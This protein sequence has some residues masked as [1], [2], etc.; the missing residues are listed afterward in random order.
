MDIAGIDRLS[1]LIKKNYPS[2]ASQDGLIKAPFL[3]DLNKTRLNG[4]SFLEEY[5]YNK[6]LS[7][8]IPF[9]NQKMDYFISSEQDTINNSRD[10][11][12]KTFSRVFVGVH[13][14]GLLKEIESQ[15]DPN[16]FKEALLSSIQLYFDGLVEGRSELPNPEVWAEQL[17]TL[18]ALL[19][20]TGTTVSAFYRKNS[21]IPFDEVREVIM[22]YDSRLIKHGS[23]SE[24][25]ERH[26]AGKEQQVGNYAANIADV[27]ESE[28][29]DL[30]MP[31]ASGGFEP[32]LLT[33]DYLG[34]KHIFP[35][36]YS[37]VSRNDNGVLVPAQ[38]PR[39]YPQQ[40]IT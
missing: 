21:E 16:N 6:I 4:V 7:P 18:N 36:R 12:P 25:K 30:I 2:Y 14:S 39:D 23:K 13:L 3:D 38:A 31:V 15:R 34:L 19:R 1:N 40:Q 22:P 32:A 37:R 24:Y 27:L 8:K 11:L 10:K 5:N 26:L 9:N 33:A 17:E 35:I 20:A 29:V 28:E